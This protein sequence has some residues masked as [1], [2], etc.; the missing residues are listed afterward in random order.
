MCIFE[1]LNDP[2]QLILSVI[3]EEKGKENLFIKQMNVDTWN[4]PFLNNSPPLVLCY[5]AI[6]GLIYANVSRSLISF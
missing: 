4:Y 3:L 2:Q 6:S 5:S 1:E